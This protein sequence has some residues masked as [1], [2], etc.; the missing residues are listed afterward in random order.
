MKTNTLWKSFIDNEQTLALSHTYKNGVYYHLILTIDDAVLSEHIKDICIQEI[1]PLLESLSDEHI[2]I[3]TI[4]GLVEH[5]L[6]KVNHAF[7]LFSEQANTNN[8]IDI[9]GAL[10]ISYQGNILVSL[11]GDSSLLICRNWKNIYNMTNTESTKKRSISQFTDY[12]SGN[13]HSG[14]SILILWF[15]HSLI[16]HSEE[17]NKIAELIH[18]NE[19]EM[20]TDLETMMSAR[21]EEKNLW[22]MSLVRNISQTLDFS[23]IN[24][25]SQKVMNYLPKG[26]INR[27]GAKTK[28]LRSQNSYAITLWV[29]A[30]IL[31]ISIY[32]IISGALNKNANN[33][34]IT[35]ENGVEIVTIDDIKKE[36]NAF[37]ELDATTSDEK[38]AKYKQIND[39]LEFLK[40]QGKRLED[41]AALQKIL[42][43]KYYEGFNII[44]INNL[45]DI[46][47]EFK[48]IY[49]LSDNELKTL[50]N[51]L[52]LMYEK[53]FYV[54]GTKG[55]L[56]KGINQDVK[57][58]PVSYSLAS[59]MKKCNLDLSKAGLYCFDNKNELY[60]VT[61]GSVTPITANSDV[62][63]PTDIRDIGTFGRNNIYLMINPTSNGGSDLIRRYTIQA[64][65][66]AAL[67]TA[68]GYKYTASG[69]GWSSA[70]NT[71]VIDG[72]FLSWS[73]DEK[74]V[75]QFQRDAATNNLNTRTIELR[76]G[77][78]TFVTYSEDV[79]IITSPSSRYVYLFDKINN[80][81]TVYNS[82]PLKTTQG[83]ELL[84][85]LQYVMRYTFDK[86]LPILDA[87]VPENNA[88][89]PMLYVMTANGIFESNLGQAITLYENK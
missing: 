12:I 53:G 42:Q 30:L 33:P 3:N 43:D 41:V 78:T 89:Q 17:L 65:N 88:N 15:D 25:Q 59:D 67:G 47:G 79:K 58:T 26:T 74:K 48:P 51:P 64:G 46:T 55:A 20:L 87:A 19:P 84:Y 69:S 35:T 14:D 16:L 23:G 39:K 70:F 31:V 82:T 60:R 7:S 71:M 11:V 40:S 56:I 75:Y 9:N 28:D 13:I 61:A 38:G 81:F 68:L 83:N 76:G 45:T 85:N 72:N 77:D 49:T 8:Y 21:T 37:Q 66:Y 52:N 50:G 6:Q 10:V 80:T 5:S 1:H 29:L 63:L 34:T 18:N 62:S 44:A 86:S 24:R 32:S 22:F 36:I 4:E 27:V 57:G 54:A 2:S 73:S